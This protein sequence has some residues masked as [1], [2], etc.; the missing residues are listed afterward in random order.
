MTMKPT[1]AAKKPQTRVITSLLSLLSGHGRPT[2]EI[3]GPRK[4]AKPAVAGP[5]HRWVG[6][7]RGTGT[8][9]S[10]FVNM[11]TCSANRWAVALKVR[12]FSVT[13]AIGDGRT[14][15]STGNTLSENRLA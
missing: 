10:D 15:K 13:S 2:L 9:G 14:G 12:F 1:S 4:R 5:V 8:T 7:H 3:T 6:R 11:R